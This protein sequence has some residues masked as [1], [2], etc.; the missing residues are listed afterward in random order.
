MFFNLLFHQK[1]NKTQNK[2]WR[3]DFE[4]YD[5]NFH[6]WG[7]YYDRSIINKNNSLIA[8]IKVPKKCDRNSLAFIEIQNIESKKIVY[9]DTTKAWNWQ[10]GCMLQW[11]GNKVT[12]IAYNIFDESTNTYKTKK[13]DLKDG[14]I[15]YFDKPV[16]TIHQIKN[17]FLSL[18]FER[19]NRYAFDYGY[20]AHK[21]QLQND[22]KTDGV[23]E[24]DMNLN[25]AKLLFSIHDVVTFQV[26]DTF[27]KAKH[28]VNHIDY[29]PD[30]RNII[31][32][33]RYCYYSQ[34]ISRLLIY[35]LDIQ[36]FHL[37]LD[38]EFV[39][40]FCWLSK[41]TL[42]IYAANQEKKLGYFSINIYT[43]YCSR[44]YKFMPSKDG[45][46]SISYNRMIVT[47]TYPDKNRIQHLYVGCLDTNSIEQIGEFYS[48]FKYIEGNRCDLHPKWSYDGLQ[49]CIDNTARKVRCI[50]VLKKEE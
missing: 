25:T 43:G 7:G 31:F 19:L 2:S 42:L 27:L 5:K 41:D 49:I 8:Y 34:H 10:Q 38:F 28:Y 13:I 46:P 50:S 37:L 1:P 26:K 14:Y 11:V 6:I 18:S 40:H 44:I 48:P 9:K 15:H 4:I 35:D 3:L 47:D 29:S 21:E 16:Y 24:V 45:H 39:S 36:T 32:I 23:W 33:H 20:N 30:G 12:E 17:C 22:D